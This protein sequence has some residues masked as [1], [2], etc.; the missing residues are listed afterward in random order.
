[1]KSQTEKDVRDS[2]LNCTHATLKATGNAN[3]L[4]T[5]NNSHTYTPTH[6][7]EA[8]ITNPMVEK[9]G[10]VQMLLLGHELPEREGPAA[11]TSKLRV[12]AASFLSRLKL[13]GAPR[14]KH[15]RCEAAQPPPGWVLRARS[16]PRSRKTMFCSRP[17]SIV[18]T[19]RRSP[20]A[21]GARCLPRG[22]Q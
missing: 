21:R 4:L 8:K 9:Y 2:K 17:I 15:D 1:M 19:S 10:H 14:A 20:R 13:L 12:F 11:K 18:S 7:R 22:L 3:I 16:Q 5:N 6:T